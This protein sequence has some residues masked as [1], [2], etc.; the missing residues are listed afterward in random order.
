MGS[1]RKRGR[2]VL[3][4][5]RIKLPASTPLA[6]SGPL[7]VTCPQCAMRIQAI[8]VWD[9]TH[10]TII[11]IKIPLHHREL[12]SKCRGSDDGFNFKKDRKGA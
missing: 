5:S 8:A 7:F 10:T 12:M 1:K 3:P 2:T 9:P 4:T 11:G 6:V